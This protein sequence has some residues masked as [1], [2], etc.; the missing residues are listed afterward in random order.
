MPMRERSFGSWCAV[1]DRDA[2]DPN[3]AFVNG[4]SP[5]MH[6]MSV[7][8]PEPHGPQ[9]T[10]TS[11]LAMLVETVGQDVD[12][13]VPLADVVDLDHRAYFRRTQPVDEPRCAEA[14]RQEDEGDEHIELGRRGCRGWQRCR[15]R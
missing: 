13:A 11:P 10:T 15:P 6:L 5:L 2:V 7:L 3:V 9:I 14:D 4:S 12:A 8:L 1:A